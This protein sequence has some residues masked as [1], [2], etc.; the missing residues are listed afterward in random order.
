[1]RKIACGYLLAFTRP[2]ERLLCCKLRDWSYDLVIEL[3]C[4]FSAWL[5]G[6]CTY[7]HV[8]VYI[9]FFFFGG[10]FPISYEL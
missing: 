7:I 8:Y 1:M 4:Y 2:S 3:I 10:E 5:P 9:F 6:Q